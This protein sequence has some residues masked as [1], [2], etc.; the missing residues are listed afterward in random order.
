VTP[1][2][3]VLPTLAR[4]PSAREGGKTAL[5]IGRGPIDRFSAE[6]TFALNSLGT[7]AK[8]FVYGAIQWLKYAKWKSSVQAV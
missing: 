5:V 6:V 2:L 3:L 1:R 8:A 4:A 7:G